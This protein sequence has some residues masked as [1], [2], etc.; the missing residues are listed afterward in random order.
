MILLGRNPWN[1]V[2]SVVQWSFA[3][4]FRL[5]SHCFD[6]FFALFVNLDN[7]YFVSTCVD[8]DLC[9]FC[10]QEMSTFT[11]CKS[12]RQFPV[13]CGNIVGYDQKYIFENKKQLRLY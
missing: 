7:F 8:L 9:D 1:F 13:Q 12:V 3:C 2:Y 6:L 4:F 5:F 11:A 10:T